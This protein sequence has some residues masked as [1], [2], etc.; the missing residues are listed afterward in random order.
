MIRYLHVLYDF[1]ELK[2]KDSSSPEAISTSVRFMPVKGHNKRESWILNKAMHTGRQG[3]ELSQEEA[4]V[5]LY[6]M[7]PEVLRAS[8]V[9]FPYQ[10]HSPFLKLCHC[11]Q[12]PLKR[13]VWW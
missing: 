7:I 6:I 8:C 11:Y 13:C 4:R 12:T 3:G 5:T 1:Q 2:K 9:S 10:Q